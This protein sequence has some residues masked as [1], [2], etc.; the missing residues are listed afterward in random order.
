[1]ADSVESAYLEYGRCFSVCAGG[2]NG[3]AA[4][5]DVA[6]ASEV[7]GVGDYDVSVRGEVAEYSDAGYVG[8]VECDWLLCGDVAGDYLG[9]VVVSG[10]DE[11]VVW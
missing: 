7:A 4:E 2:G 1:M 6:C 9:V 11:G 10:P 5:L 8:C 3:L